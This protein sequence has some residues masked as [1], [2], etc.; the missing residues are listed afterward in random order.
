M[1]LQTRKLNQPPVPANL[2]IEKQTNPFLRCEEKS[3]INAASTWAGRILNNP[4]EVFA[5][6]RSW[7]D[8][9]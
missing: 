6:I 4:V 3:V 5:T 7:K 9:I 8:S 2:E 1:A